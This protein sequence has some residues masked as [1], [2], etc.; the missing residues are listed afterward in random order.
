MRKVE[1]ERIP[2]S[3]ALSAAVAR[4]LHKLMAYKDEYEVARLYSDTGFLERVAGMFEGDWRLRFHLA[5]PL[6]AGPDPSTG[7]PEKR[8]YGQWMLR[9][10][11]LLAKLKRPARH[12]ARPVR[13]HGRAAPRSGN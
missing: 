8:A 13:P 7:E 10:F 12:S 5:P 6:I 4:N 3:E 1:A 2:G 11:R 9:A